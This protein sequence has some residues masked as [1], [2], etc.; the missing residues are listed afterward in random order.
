MFRS[1]IP[2]KS[3]VFVNDNFIQ[4]M[5]RINRDSVPSCTQLMQ[6]NV[7][8]V[9]ISFARPIELLV[10]LEQVCLHWSCRNL[11]E[12]HREKI[13]EIVG[14]TLEEACSKKR[15]NFFQLISTL[16]CVV[17]RGLVETS[18]NVPLL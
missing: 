2:K 13:I 15:A 18:L 1:F 5:K 9:V 6:S 12:K 11:G 7:P 10:I 8:V 4:S 14:A 3:S 17:M 16:F